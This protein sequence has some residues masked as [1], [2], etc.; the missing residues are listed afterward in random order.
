MPQHVTS[1]RTYIVIYAIL[2]LLLALTIRLA[3]ADLGRLE[4]LPA[5]LIAAL[6]GILV[7][8]FFMELRVQSRVTWLLAGVGF[9]W[10]GVLMVLSMADYTT[11]GWSPSDEMLRTPPRVIIPPR[12]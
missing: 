6:K 10:L 5:Y 2:M 11:R 4:A 8:I 1:V 3:F 9:V 7:M 12:R